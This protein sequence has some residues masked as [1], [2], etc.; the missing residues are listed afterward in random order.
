[1]AQRDQPLLGW[2]EEQG[3]RDEPRRLADDLRPGRSAAGGAA[4]QLAARAE[5]RGV[6]AFHPRLLAESGGHRRLV[7]AAACREADLA[8]ERDPAGPGSQTRQTDHVASK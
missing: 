8:A 7:D 4:R 6:L 3:P 2:H 5:Q 1:R